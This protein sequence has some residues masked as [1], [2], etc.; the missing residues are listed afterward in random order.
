MS[1]NGIGHCSHWKVVP[2]QCHDYPTNDSLLNC[3][4]TGKANPFQGIP[5]IGKYWNN[6]TNTDLVWWRAPD[7]LFW[8]C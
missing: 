5:E 7:G 6:L 3:S 4:T 1:L 2:N 8:I